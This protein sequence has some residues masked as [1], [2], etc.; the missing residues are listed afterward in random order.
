MGFLSN[1]LG[2]TA[3][4]EVGLQQEGNQM[5][6]KMLQDRLATSTCPT[7]RANLQNNINSIQRAMQQAPTPQ[8][9]PSNP[10]QNQ[11]NIRPQLQALEQEANALKASL[12]RIDGIL[13]NLKSQA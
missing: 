4:T 3:P 1:L 6:L 5:M 11:P 9:P 7:E 2:K 8:M 10:A 13:A 12:N